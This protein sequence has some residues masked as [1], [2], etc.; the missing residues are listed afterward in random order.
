MGTSRGAS[1]VASR[2]C[3]SDQPNRHGVLRSTCAKH[4]AQTQTR[5]GVGCKRVGACDRGGS[6]LACVT[7]HTAHDAKRRHSHI[8]LLG[9]LLSNAREQRHLCDLK[10]GAAQQQPP[11]M[12]SRSH[13]GLSARALASARAAPRA[14][15]LLPPH[16]RTSLPSGRRTLLL[17]STD[18][19]LTM[20]A[21]SS[22]VQCVGV[23]VC[24]GGC[25][26]VHA[27]HEV[28]VASQR[29][30]APGAPGS[31]RHRRGA[32][33]GHSRRAA[34]A[35]RRHTRRDRAQSLLSIDV[36]AQASPPP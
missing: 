4:T 21:C 32:C 3:M 34:A 18:A 27:G 12:L 11:C 29:A 6:C 2:R 5:Q 35:A 20:D 30:R 8:A 36:E 15:P 17:R 1:V 14:H 7:H 25:G 19:M 24:V 16:A 26:R 22:G 28:V 31:H 10:C 33:P 13:R 9:V 23:C